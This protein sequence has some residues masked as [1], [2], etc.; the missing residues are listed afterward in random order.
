M[1]GT[2]ICL[3]CIL[4]YFHLTAAQLSQKETLKNIT[5]CVLNA[6]IRLTCAGDEVIAIHSLQYAYHVRCD[7]TCCN[8]YTST[9]CFADAEDTDIQDIRR[10]CSGRSSCNVLNLP[11][12][13][14]FCSFGL[15]DI[16]YVFLQYFCIPEERLAS[17]CSNGQTLTSDDAPLYLTN[18]NYPSVTTGSESCSCSLE[19]YSCSSSIN[20]YIMDADLYLDTSNCYQ[21]LEFLDGSDKTLYVIGCESHYLNQIE[22]NTANSHYLKIDFINNSTSNQEGYFFIGLEA[23]ESG[24]SFRLSC[25]YEKETWCAGCGDV[26]VIA[27]GNV[28]LSNVNDS[29]Y[30]AAAN[31]ICDSGYETNTPTINCLANGTWPDP[32]CT[33]KDC[34]TLPAISSG[35]Y[36]LVGSSTTFGASAR[37]MCDEGHKAD[38]QSVNCQST[39][40]WGSAVCTLADCGT[41]PD[42]V[43][44]NVT[45]NKDNNTTFAATASVACEEG[46]QPAKVSITCQA[47]GKWETPLCET[48]AQLSQ[49]ETLK[50]ITECDLNAGIRLTCAG[51]EVIAIHSVQYAYNVS[52]EGTC[53]HTYTSTHCFADAEDTDIQDIRRACSGRSSCNVLNLPDKVSFCSFGLKDI[54]YVFLQYFCIPEERLASICSNGQTLTSDDA[55][56]YLTNENYPSVTTG[57]GS[58]SC[59]LEVYSCSSSINMYIMDADLYL[60][61]NNCNQILE[62]LDGSDKTLYTIGCESHYLNQIENNTANSHYLKLNFI[63]NSTSYQEGYLFIGLEASESGASFKLSC[64]YEEETWCAGCGDV[65]VIANGN[66]ELSNMNDSSYEAAANVICD[67]GYETNTPTLNCLANGTWPAPDCTEKAACTASQWRCTN[68]DCVLDSQRCDNVPDCTDQSDEENCGDCLQRPLETVETGVSSNI[69]A[70]VGVGVGTFVTTLIIVTIVFTLY[71][72]LRLRRKHTQKDVNNVRDAHRQK[73]GTGIDSETS[74]TYESL[75]DTKKERNLYSQL[76]ASNE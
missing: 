74:L 25:S 76:S 23:S 40:I 34:G 75:D 47:S 64:S 10:D 22:N 14:S 35:K 38:K 63:N 65:P 6:G 37:V 61:T 57:S 56:L 7:G 42:V 5:E 26:P 11:D 44:G 31:V 45:L 62:F 8:T 49:K 16:S 17:I 66:I 1:I 24:A 15:K 55:P 60:D 72:C 71:R 28:E 58:C 3:K 39:G 33:E 68:G 54:S 29:S 4:I 19:V 2:F 48:V 41:V 30:E 20:M 27:N 18:D 50:N 21:T 67:S 59:S 46:Y 53:C 36:E 52:C 12:K 43:N 73:T 32:V 9:H 13:V 69:G 51:D 70:F